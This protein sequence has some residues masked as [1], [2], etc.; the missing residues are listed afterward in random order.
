MSAMLA[1]PG[2]LQVYAANL[3]GFHVAMHF[4]TH[5]PVIIADAAM[6]VNRLLSTMVCRYLPACL[7]AS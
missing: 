6:V 3:K 7:L 5:Y 1:I 2:V 4:F